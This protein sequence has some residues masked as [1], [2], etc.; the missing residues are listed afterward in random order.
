MDVSLL[1][2]LGVIHPSANA[3]DSNCFHRMK[4]ACTKRLVPVG[5]P[6]ITSL[7]W[8]TCHGGL[9]W[10]LG[11]GLALTRPPLYR[12]WVRWP[13]MIS[14]SSVQCPAGCLWLGGTD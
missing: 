2:M 9:I 5:G 12:A 11:E 1:V 3:P 6:L 7:P 8:L 13:R 10:L 14:I 4:E